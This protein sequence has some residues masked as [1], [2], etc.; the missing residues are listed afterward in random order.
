MSELSQRIVV[1]SLAVVVAAGLAIDAYVHLHYAS[2]YALVRTSAVS[3]ADLFRA[4]G[5][6]AALCGLWVL[7]RPGRWSGL[8]AFLVAAGGAGA[9]ALYTY[10]DPGK[11]GPLPDMY[12]PVW[13]SDKTLS[14]VAESAAAVVA[15]V[16]VALVVLPRRTVGRAEPSH[17]T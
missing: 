15:L 8:A 12:E 2:S 7:V 13:F 10:V 16:M 17:A 5:V 14:F 1:R 9:V 3:Q 11:L 6:V 4:E